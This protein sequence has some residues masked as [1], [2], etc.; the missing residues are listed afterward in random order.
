MHPPWGL[1]LTLCRVGADSNIPSPVQ[2]E[3]VPCIATRTFCGGRTKDHI[4]ES[5]GSGVAMFDYDA[6]GRLDI[7]LVTAF[8]LS[9]AREKIP[10]RNALYRNEGDWTFRDVSAGSGLDVA[11]WGNGVCA[12]DYDNDGRLDLYV[13]NFGPNFLFHNNGNGTFTDVAPDA[14]VAFASPSA[15]PS[16]SSAYVLEHRL[17]V[18]RR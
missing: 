12:G 5:G 3:E 16:F 7:Y 18:L 4:L 2:F 11:A 15:G 14:G 8:E 10:H 9:D 6:D 1:P 17:H 13:T